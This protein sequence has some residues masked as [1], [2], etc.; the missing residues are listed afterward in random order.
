MKQNSKKIRCAGKA[1]TIIGKK[2]VRSAANTQWVALPRAWPSALARFGKI[3]EMKT[4]ITVP[5]PMAWAAI[6]AK[7]Q[8]G[9]IV[10]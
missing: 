4:Q 10:K 9:T 8:V 6:N 1:S 5:W 7:M 3:S 2:V